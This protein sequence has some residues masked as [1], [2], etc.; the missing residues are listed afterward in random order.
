[1]SITSSSLLV[2]MNINVWTANKL[3]RTETDKVTADNAAVKNA[4]KVHKNLMAGTALR[5]NIADFASGCRTL[6]LTKTLPWA[7][8]GARLLPMTLFF[9]YK[10]EVNKLQAQFDTMVDEFVQQY[11]ALVQTAQNYLGGLF[12]PRDYPS[13]DVVRSKFGFKI[14][15]SPVP[16]AGDFRVD[17]PA[18]ELRE[19]SQQYEASF[20]ERM[21]DA[22]KEPWQ[23]LHK[24]LSEMST[25]LTERE[26]EV[27]RIYHDSLVEN[28]VN[29]CE[30]LTHLNI[31]KDPKLEEARQLLEAT[32]TG[33]NVDKLKESIV[34]RTELKAKVDAILKQFD[35]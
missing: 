16:E 35:W 8:R 2:E 18:E 30:M 7:D 20:T 32:M 23:R 11:P 34:S 25:K 28:A 5:K 17:V 26:G 29:L 10:T 19:L 1:M 24:L 27:K 13:A 22:M 15:F 3:D 21:G 4:A 31:T 14:T 33:A 9:D 6:H 12:D